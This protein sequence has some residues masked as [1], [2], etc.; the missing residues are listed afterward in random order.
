[1][2]LLRKNY[3]VEAGGELTELTLR[4][5]RRE[6]SVGGCSERRISVFNFY[7]T[8]GPE[9]FAGPHS[10]LAAGECSLSH[11]MNASDQ[12]MLSAQRVASTNGGSPCFRSTQ[13]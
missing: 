8:R 7:C 1:V 12:H 2:K 3:V 11:R 10:C 13:G 4:E 6:E 9:N 5:G